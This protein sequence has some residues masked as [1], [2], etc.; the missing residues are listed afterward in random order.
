MDNTPN[1]DF[2]PEINYEKSLQKHRLIYKTTGWFL[3]NLIFNYT[4][5]MLVMF[6]AFQPLLHLITGSAEPIWLIACSILIVSL[7]VFNVFCNSAF[8]KIEGKK[9]EDNK[10]DILLIMDEF[11]SNYDFKVND[12][13]MMRSFMP[14]G[15]PIWGRIITILF[16]GKVMY[17]NITSLGK[18]N[19]PTIVHGL[20][21]FIKAKR[22]ARYYRKNYFSN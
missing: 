9:T 4:L 21:N 2:S 22:I 18:T 10:K 19:S 12:D 3:F 7:M 6:V 5:Y 17:L 20:Y 15:S 8:T 16:D 1:A 11:F 14:Q 13:K